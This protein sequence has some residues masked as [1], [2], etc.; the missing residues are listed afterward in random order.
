MN[1]KE[2]ERREGGRKENRM[3]LEYE[4][5]CFGGKGEIKKKDD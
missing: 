4:V 5:W 3:I 2:Q 1:E